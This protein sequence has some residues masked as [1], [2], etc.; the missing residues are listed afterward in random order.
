MTNVAWNDRNCICALRR[1]SDPFFSFKRRTPELVTI[2][3]YVAKI[4]H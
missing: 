2:V 3:V 1:V 4:L